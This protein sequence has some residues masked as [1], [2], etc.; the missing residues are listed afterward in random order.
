MAFVQTDGKSY[1]KRMEPALKT[2]NEIVS[3]GSIDTQQ[4]DWEDDLSVRGA[5]KADAFDS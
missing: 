4:E 3:A 5:P 1:S 2:L